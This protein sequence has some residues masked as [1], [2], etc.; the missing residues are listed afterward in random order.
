MDA[1]K[2]PARSGFHYP[3]RGFLALVGALL[4]A[5]AACQPPTKGPALWRLADAD[6]E[7]WLFGTV[8]LLP[9]NITWRTPR[10]NN[11]FARSDTVVFET[12]TR[13]S[14]RRELETLFRERGFDRTGPPL[15]AK[16]APPDRERLERIARKLNVD[17]QILERM[18]P[19]FA[20]L[21]LSFLYVQSTGQD[22][23]AGVE[24]IL[25]GEATRLGK[26][27][28]FLETAAQQVGFLADLPPH[29]ELQFLSTS[30]RQIEEEESNLIELDRAWASGDTRRLA[31]LL[32]GLIE[33][34]GPGVYRALIT[35]RNRR[36]TAQIEQMLKG[37]GRIFIAVGAAHLVGRQSVIE[38]LRA[39]G[40]KVEGP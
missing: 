3:R 38:Q 1:I 20:A 5:L 7:I 30:L 24:T 31:E 12:D 15:S 36:W 22:P 34:A 2:T 35:D 26:R 14:G 37:R 6:S 23:A 19:W 28:A 21:K 8:H 4:L 33:E 18:R 9:H 13:G 27:Q 10:I 40:Y 16:L 29:V 17:R 25:A 11:A 39:D 32:N